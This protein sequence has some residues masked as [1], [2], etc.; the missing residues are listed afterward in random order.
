MKGW[1]SK[2]VRLA[3]N[4][5]FWLSTSAAYNANY[6]NTVDQ[7]VNSIIGLGMGVII[8]LHWSDCGILSQATNCQ[9]PMADQNS[10]TF[11]TQV[12]TKYKNNPSIMF[13]LY[14]EPMQIPWTIWKDGGSLSNSGSQCS[15]PSTFTAVGMQDLYNAVRGT[16]ANNIVIIG[17][18]DYAYDLSGVNNGYAITGTN[19]AYATHPYD[20]P[21]NK[22]P[23][24]W[25]TF[26][27]SVAASHA[28][29][30]T[31]FGQYCA[32]DGYVAKWLN[33]TKHRNIAFT[34]WAWWVQDCNFPSI[35]TDWNGTPDPTIG[36]IIKNDILNQ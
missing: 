2:I 28:V 18:I 4:Q 19:I 21:G 32:N 20:Y 14:N 15:C 30:S 24:N 11:W 22:Q 26:V 10:I 7:Q 35:I 17:G 9:Q 5:G 25:D 36:T 31:E 13:E 29:I 3:L 33:Y 1:G 6:Q 8:D 16:G 23:S 27:G 12:A 34:A